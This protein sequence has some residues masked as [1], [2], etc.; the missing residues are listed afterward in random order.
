M[1]VLLV[2]RGVYALGFARALASSGHAVFLATTDEDDFASRSSAVRAAFVV[3][4]PD[5][6]APRAW[7]IALRSAVAS[8]APD[9]IVPVL[10]ETLYLAEFCGEEPAWAGTAM[11]LCAP[12]E[13]LALMHSK[14]GFAQLASTGGSSALVTP[15]TCALED[16][17]EPPRVAVLI[18]R[19]FSRGAVGH[20]LWCP[21]EPW[22]P[23]ECADTPAPVAAP[24]GLAVKNRWLVQHFVEGEP[25]STFAVV[26][27]GRVAAHVTYHCE[28]AASASAPPCVA[29]DDHGSAGRSG[30]ARRHVAGFAALRR[31]VEC[32]DAL[33]ATE[34]YVRALVSHGALVP[35][36]D[37]F[38]LLGLDF[39]REALPAQCERASLSRSPAERGAQQPGSPRGGARASGAGRPCA[40]RL[41]AL[42][43]NPRATNGLALLAASPAACRRL[44]RTLELAAARTGTGSAGPGAS[45]CA[46]PFALAAEEA[47]AASRRRAQAD[48]ALSAETVEVVPAGIAMRSLVPA[49][50]AAAAAWAALLATPPAPLSAASVV[51][52]ADRALRSLVSLA[53]ASD[54]LAR[55]DDWRP[56]LCAAT[57]LV[58]ALR[59]GGSAEVRR[60]V[61][62]A[63]VQWP[64]R[65]A[66][67]GQLDA[68]PAA[69]P[70]VELYWG[71]R[72]SAALGARASAEPPQP[73]A[74]PGK[75]GEASTRADEL[76]GS[77]GASLVGGPQAGAHEWSGRAGELRYAVSYM[78]MLAEG[79]VGALVRNVPP[80][81]TVG[82]AVVGRECMP[83]PLLAAP[84]TPLRDP[85]GRAGGDAGSERGARAR[86]NG[87]GPRWAGLGSAYTA[88]TLSHFVSYVYDEVW[89]LAGALPEL[90]AAR[91]VRPRWLCRPLAACLLCLA[92]ALVCCWGLLARACGLG[93]SLYINSWLLS[94]SLPPRLPQCRAE[95]RRELAAL[96]RALVAACPRHALV[97]R[98]VDA[99][100]SA[101]LGAAL[102]SLGWLPVPARYVHYRQVCEPALWRLASVRGD[103]RHAARMLSAM[104]NGG[105]YGWRTLAPADMAE[106]APHAHALACA[107]V[108][109]YE[110]LYVG[111]YSRHNPRFTPAFVRAAVTNRLLIVLV[112]VDEQ[113]G[114]PWQES[115]DGCFGY[116]TRNGFTTNPIF[117][118]DT[119]KPA[120]RGLYRLVAL[121]SAQEG[122]RLRLHCHSSGG[123]GDYKRKRGAVSV[124]EVCMVS[125]SHLPWHRRLPWWLLHL[126][127]WHVA[128]RFLRLPGGPACA[129]PP[130][131]DSQ[132]LD[133]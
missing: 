27:C 71:E 98:S 104:G 87:G 68:A 54:D 25:L 31:T 12:F 79:P 121:R 122:L 61:L 91:G 41:L 120:A 94:T 123:A 118:Y 116:Y 112:L 62:G 85:A 66:P 7:R 81:L 43:C 2:G 37:R 18:K 127:G 103:Q 48:E 64:P 114:R 69:E 74:Q 111:K 131:A 60:R 38:V 36:R 50:G 55:L 82:L 58:R 83:I 23:A 80:G 39:V 102:G 92:S 21:G 15:A 45:P 129:V 28:L 132:Q 10:E 56:A 8:C 99:L 32:A 78:R 46:G 105:R 42:E 11:T 77:D 108:R 72:V 30:G 24:D 88:C 17:I 33:S 100:G 70:A 125:V 86:G 109:L 106:D 96:E 95:L 113:S 3:P 63:I 6:G 119:A 20:V 97:F 52:A 13:T 76:P 16:Q 115:L 93:R 90:L 75:L 9:V 5:R 1:R 59:R 19:D 29:R 65:A 128:V 22:P 51:R 67:P 84:P 117:G 107:V 44:A 126:V 133:A 14:W 26:C 130:L 110:L 34:A 53:R 57:S 47:A 35:T 4:A 101:E 49:L 89:I 40:G 73:A 124:V